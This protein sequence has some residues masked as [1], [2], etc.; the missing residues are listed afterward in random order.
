MKYISPFALLG[1][2]DSANAVIER[3]DL[4]LARKKLMAEIE[5][6]DTQ[7]VKINGTEFSKDG[8]IKLFEEYEEEN[9]MGYHRLVAQDKALLAF[10][11]QGFISD[12]NNIQKRPEYES[13]GF[14]DFVS[15]YFRERFEP[16]LN[17][18]FRKKD[19]F[20]LMKLLRLNRLMTSSDEEASFRKVYEELNDVV[21]QLST[22]SKAIR[23]KGVFT[24]PADKSIYYSRNF[25]S[26]ISLLPDFFME[27]RNQIAQQLIILYVESYNILK[28]SDIS[29]E[30]IRNL[31]SLKVDEEM[32]QE[33]K[34]REAEF[35][36]ASASANAYSYGKTSSGGG[37]KAG[38]GAIIFGLVII[39]KLL[40]FSRNCGGSRHTDYSYLNNR[41]WSNPSLYSQ[42]QVSPP[43]GSLVYEDADNKLFFAFLDSVYRNQ[44]NVVTKTAPVNFK[45]RSKPAA[46]YA[47]ILKFDNT[48]GDMADTGVIVLQN[49]S[50]YEVCAIVSSRAGARAWNIQPGDSVVVRS[51]DKYHKIYYT[52]GYKMDL[53]KKFRLFTYDN[54]LGHYK[55]KIFNP[56]LFRTPVEEAGE[57]L[58]N[59]ETINLSQVDAKIFKGTRNYALLSIL[60]S[61]SGVGNICNLRKRIQFGSYPHRLTVSVRDESSL[62]VNPGANP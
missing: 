42:N 11:D 23:D 30:I 56:K 16:E 49:Y 3:K 28:R 47:D 7:T 9:V 50:D 4:Q 26:A 12:Y 53:K 20:S 25:L 60:A 34:K 17:A 43:D 19:Y 8:I 45:K 21:G 5:L 33:L 46:L 59:P 40:L 55:S 13:G 32:Q 62:K 22:L 1:I 35:N 39:V 52:G 31:F 61:G 37:G 38:V 24:V 18:V 36:N 2:T 54:N 14:I 51:R 15:P 6:G 10:L 41:S 58:M 57:H 27:L 48:V 44:A 29:G